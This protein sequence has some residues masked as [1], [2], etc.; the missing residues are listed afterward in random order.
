M[1]WLIIISF[2]IYT[3]IITGFRIGSFVLT[4]RWVKGEWAELIYWTLFGTSTIV[5]L[6]IP[7]MGQ[8]MLLLLFTLFNFGQMSMTY[9]YWFIHNKERIRKKVEGYN[10][11]FAHTHH[12][13]KPRVDVLIPDTFH[14]IL[15]IMF[16]INLIAMVVYII[17]AR[18]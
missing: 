6:L 1:N 13:I 17:T 16:F 10:K 12:V 7:D 9:K 18:L 14:I 3:L 8:W 15:F 11:C 2:C 5:F 4:S